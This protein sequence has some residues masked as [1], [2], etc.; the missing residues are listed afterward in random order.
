[1]F[2]TPPFKYLQKITYL[3]FDHAV[4]SP[5]P[6]RPDECRN[7]EL[8]EIT[9]LRPLLEWQAEHRSNFLRIDHMRRFS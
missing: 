6:G 3:K 9:G 4:K 7:P 5:K 1:M 2:Y 8:P